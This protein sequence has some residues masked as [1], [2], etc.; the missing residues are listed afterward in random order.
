[1][2]QV[3]HNLLQLHYNN[4]TTT[5]CSNITCCRE[6]SPGDKVQG[7]ASKIHQPSSWPHQESNETF[8]C[9]FQQANCSFLL[10]SCTII[11]MCH[12]FSTT[13]R[14]YARA[15]CLKAILILLIAVSQLQ[16][17][18]DLPKGYSERTEHAHST[19]IPLRW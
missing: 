12:D 16:C 19:V 4:N 5:C 13:E 7:S 1:M 2:L 18:R 11:T 17:Y 6:S 8:T 10:Q 9:A 3:H 15:H 14:L